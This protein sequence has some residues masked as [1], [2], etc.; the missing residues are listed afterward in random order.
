MNNNLI[1]ENQARKICPL[2]FDE[3]NP[4]LEFTF[5]CGHTVDMV[6]YIQY[7]KVKNG[8]FYKCS[9]CRKQLKKTDFENDKFLF[10]VNM[11]AQR[12]NIERT[13]ITARK[14]TEQLERTFYNLEQEPPQFNICPLVLF[15]M[16][17]ESRD[18]H[19]EE[20]EPEEEE[21][22]PE[23]EEA[24]PEE[25]EAEPEE[26]EAEPE[27]EAPE[28]EEE[29]ENGTA[30][31]EEIIKVIKV[32]IYKTI[33]TMTREKRYEEEDR[34]KTE[35]SIFLSCKRLLL[36]MTDDNERY[37]NYIEKAKKRFK[38]EEETSEEETSE[39]DE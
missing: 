34:T 32:L 10:L 5:N 4:N 14:Q 25:E 22:E 17:E 39:E 3:I 35:M 7:M 13:E 12:E 38:K 27:E 37:D 30:D 28:P 18:Y 19:D 2:T 26:E 15:S 8:A 24:E 29:E 33:R 23:E 1:I 36:L 6:E 21:P 31:T 20:A 9:E 11:F 16:C